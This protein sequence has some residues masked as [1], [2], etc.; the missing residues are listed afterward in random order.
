LVPGAPSDRFFLAARHRTH[1]LKNRIHLIIA[2]SGLWLGLLPLSAADFPPDFGKWPMAT[3]ESQGMSTAK[4]QAA[5]AAV[6]NG[7]GRMIVI[8]NGYD[9]WH[10]GGD[11]YARKTGWASVGRSLMTMMYG[12]M[13]MDGTIAG[14]ADVLEGPVNALPCDEARKFGDDVLLKHLLS[15]TSCGNPP[16]SRYRYHCNYF[17]MYRIV[18]QIDGRQPSV[19][20]LNLGRKIGADWGEHLSLVHKDKGGSPF[21]TI[22]S[23]EADAA[24]WGYLWMNEGK[25]RDGVIVPAWFVKRSLEPMPSPLGG[26]ADENQGW[27]IHTNRGGGF[28]DIIPRD[29]FWKT[30]GGRRL[31]FGSPSLGLIFAQT[32]DPSYDVKATAEAVI[33]CIVD[34]TGHSRPGSEP[35]REAHLR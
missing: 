33:Q 12:E 11:P 9:V 7:M 32:I 3:P 5:P 34:R 27:Q 16:G 25:W 10:Y 19:R 14:G 23:T 4:L 6:S 8:R 31:I 13:I 1:G 29:A 2:G 20:L 24:R 30:G 28:G 35:D 26:H 21:L 18:E 15:Y 22:S 17:S